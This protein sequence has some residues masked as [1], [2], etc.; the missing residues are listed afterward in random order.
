MKCGTGRIRQVGVEIVV[1]RAVVWLQV[2]WH[3]CHQ[4]RFQFS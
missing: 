2:V 3:L 4:K 1:A